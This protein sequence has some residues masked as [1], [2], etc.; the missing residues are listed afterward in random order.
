[1]WPISAN[2]IG[3]TSIFCLTSHLLQ[4]FLGNLARS[5]G[6]DTTL[7]DVLQTLDK[8]YGV[9]MSFD[10]LS[11]ELYSL[12]QGSGE[13]VAEFGWCLLQ[14][15]QILHSE[16]PRRIQPQHVEEMK[17]DCFYEGFNPKYWWMLAHKVDGKNPAGYSDLLLATWRLERRADAG[18]PLPPKTAVTSGLNVMHSQTL[19]DLFPFHKLKG[20]HTFTTRAVTTGNNEVEQEEQISLWSISF[21][22]PRQLDYTNR[23]TEVVLCV[24]VPTTSCGT[25]QDISK[26]AWKVDLNTKEGMAKVGG[27]APHTWLQLSKYPWMRLPKH[28]DTMKDSFHKFRPTHS[29]ELTQKHS[30]G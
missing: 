8:H 9:I 24:G 27:W 10:T 7:S 25:A 28:K 17:C 23:K 26:I 4:E 6:E 12:K 22:L 14:Q 20:N 21:A 18:D 30:L 13:N 2:Q 3:M 16:Y 15:V 5:L 1:M 19:G 11:K 29:L